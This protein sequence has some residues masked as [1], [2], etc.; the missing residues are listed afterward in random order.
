MD[1]SAAAR[2]ADHLRTTVSQLRIA[3]SESIVADHFTASIGAVTGRLDGA[4][5]RTPLLAQAIATVAGAG[6]SGGNRVVAVTD[7]P[8]IQPVAHDKKVQTVHS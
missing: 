2:L 4:V 8:S 7:A 5:D 1:A 3:N 6:R